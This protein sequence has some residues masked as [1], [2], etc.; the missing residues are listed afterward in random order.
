MKIKVLNGLIIIDVLTILFIA[1]TVF[2]PSGILHIILGIPFI[3]F[4]PGYTLVT[5]LFSKREELSGIEWVALS[6]VM[7]IAVVGLIGL[8]LNYTAWGIRLRPV[9]YSISAFIIVMSTVALFIRA[10][11]HKQTKLTVELKLR[12]SSLEGSFLKPLNIILIVCI[13]SALGVLGYIATTTNISEKYTEFYILGFYGKAQDYP[14]EFN[15]QSNH[16]TRV[17]YGG[18][19][20]TT[21]NLGNVTLGVV[22]HEQRQIVYSIIIKIDGEQVN[23]NYPGQSINQIGQVTLDQGEKWEQEIGFAPQHTGVNQKVEF[24]LY[25]EGDSSPEESLNIW[26]NV[27]EV[28]QSSADQASRI[29][30]PSNIYK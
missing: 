28:Q 16:V 11:L 24:L 12:L 26:I 20:D 9:L 7:S 27:K 29:S 2:I 22:N 30:R 25:K 17:N 4:F 14:L 5:V 10:K 6:L 15:L 8:G 18:I 13:L 1:I 19:Y 21:D 23:I 3:S